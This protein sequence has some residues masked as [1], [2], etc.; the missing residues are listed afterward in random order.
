MIAL[1]TVI[2]YSS[3]LPVF[4]MIYLFAWANVPICPRLV[5][6]GFFGALVG[7]NNFRLSRELAIDWAKQEYEETQ[8]AHKKKLK[9]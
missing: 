5:L 4:F 3:I 9:K 2:F 8:K 6:T 7:L 1:I